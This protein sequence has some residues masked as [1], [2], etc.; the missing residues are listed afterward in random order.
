MAPRNP[1]TSIT[2]TGGAAL[3]YWGDELRYYREQAGLTQEHLARRV[4]V[5]SSLVAMI[6]TG[7]RAPKPDFINAADTAL[8]TGGA[9]DRL[10]KRIIKSSYLE[11]FRLFVEVEAEADSILKYEQQS[12]PGLLQNE[13]YARAQFRNGRVRDSDETIERQVAAR[14]SRQ[15]ILTRD[16][17]PFLWVILEEAVLRRRVGGVEVMREQ[18]T[19]LVRA[20]ESPDIIIQMLPFSI[21]AHAGMSGSMTLFSL[22][23][24][25]DLAYSENFAGGQIIGRPDEVEECRLR[26]DLL[27]ANALPPDESV[28]MIAGMI[29]EP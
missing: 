12:V 10:W 21:G 5:S 15:E 29:G 17:P 23:D 20:A 25:G 22:P 2:V 28:R 18:C 3:A 8:N 13:D 19:R 24:H 1:F 6:E 27:R 16:N 4:F 7:R 11:W 14:M 9:L 26:L